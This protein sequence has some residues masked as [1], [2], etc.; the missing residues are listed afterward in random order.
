MSAVR[1]IAAGALVFAAWDYFRNKGA[2]SA[3]DISFS[4]FAEGSPIG[5]AFE[6]VKGGASAALDYVEASM[7]ILRLSAMRNVSP[8][9]LQ[10]S[11]VQAFLRVLRTGEGTADEKGYRRL[12]GGG[13]FSSYADHPRILKSGTFRSGAKWSS[14]AAGAYQALASTWD[15]TK[16]IMALPDFSPASQD[17][18]AL[19]RI[20]AR[21]ALD[22]VLEGRIESA[23]R[24]CSME[25]ASLPGSP[26]GQPTISLARAVDVYA[27][28]GGSV[29]A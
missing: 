26:Y 12:V 17:M 2:V 20:A 8:S 7:P 29:F 23:L 25:W 3:I 15:E 16:R 1:V 28:S 27:S 21:G 19:G 5:N 4:P 10:N 9:L 11:N 18:F 22:D 24:K 6:T 13:E 14:T